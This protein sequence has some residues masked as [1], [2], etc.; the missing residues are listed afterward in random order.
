MLVNK[1]I[2]PRA[3]SP[4]EK[5]NR[6]AG[7]YDSFANYLVFC[8]K[9][10]HPIKTNMYIQSAESYIEKLNAQRKPCHVC[11]E[12]EWTLGYPMGS[13]TGFVKF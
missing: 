3:L 11:G 10:S 12:C 8:P 6:K 4:E 1:R 13:K 7:V 2:S 5:E 9:C